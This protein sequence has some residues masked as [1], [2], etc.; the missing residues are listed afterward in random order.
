MT[1]AVKYLQKKQYLNAAF[2]PV[3]WFL[4]AT[5]GRHSVHYISTYW[6]WSC[7]WVSSIVL[8]IIS[9]FFHVFSSFL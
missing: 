9:L 3:H 4:S 1:V 8:L 7:W 5:D 2:Q 6:N